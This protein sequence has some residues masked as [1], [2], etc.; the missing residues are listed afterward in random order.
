MMTSPFII[1][2]FEPVSGNKY[3]SMS[4]IYIGKRDK[5]RVF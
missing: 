4:Y 5:Y 3:H 1:E 2:K